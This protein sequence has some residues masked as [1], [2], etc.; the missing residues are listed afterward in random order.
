M[1]CS[2]GTGVASHAPRCL[3]THPANPSAFFTW[4]WSWR[5]SA[6]LAAPRSSSPVAARPPRSRRMETRRPKLLRRMAIVMRKRAPTRRAQWGRLQRPDVAC[7]ARWRSARASLATSVAGPRPQTNA[8]TGAATTDPG[9][10][11]R[12]RTGARDGRPSASH[13]MQTSFAS[14][15]PWTAERTSSARPKCGQEFQRRIGIRSG[16]PFCSVQ[17]VQRD[18]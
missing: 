10:E 6:R 13:R 16:V 7:A 12:T 5:C 11:R 18:G 3:A 4:A 14:S 1:G 9:R 15:A 2:A 8:S 17:P